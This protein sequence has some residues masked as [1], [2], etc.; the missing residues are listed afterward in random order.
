MK[1]SDEAQD[2]ARRIAGLSKAHLDGDQ[3]AAAELERLAPEEYG[4]PEDLETP[5]LDRP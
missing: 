3:S 1:L 5:D 4:P 2:K